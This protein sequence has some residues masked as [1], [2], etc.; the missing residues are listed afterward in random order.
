[1]TKK[2]PDEPSKW[3]KRLVYKVACPNCW[4]SFFPE[5]VLFIA[6]HPGLVG[7][8]VAGSNEYLRF[9]PE[10]FTVKGE[11][12]DPRGVP[13]ADL[14]CPRCHLR[15]PEIMLE[16]HPLFISLI[17]S[18]ASGKSY[19]LT[20]M[21]HSLRTILPRAGLQFTDADPHANEPILD[22][23]RTLFANPHTNRPT[24]IRKSQLDDTR[25]HRFIRSNEM[26]IRVPVPLQFRLWPQQNHPGFSDAYSIG[27][28]IVMYD[29]AGEDFRP[30]TEDPQ[31][32]AARHLAASR[33]L[34]VLLDLT[35]EPQFREKS[36]RND[37][38]LK[39]GL[40]PGSA[41]QNVVDSQQ[42]IL[43]EAAVRLRRYLGISEKDRVRTPL[44][45]IVPKFDIWEEL[46]GVS[47][48]EEPYETSDGNSLLAM[49]TDAVDEV[50]RQI[51]EV[52]WRFCPAFVSTA[53]GLSEVVRYVPVS[54]L[55]RSP[56]FIQQEGAGYYGICPRDISPKW[57]TVPLLYCL[58]KWA[59][60][61]IARRHKDHQH[62][63]QLS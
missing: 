34:F 14:A 6:K 54:S 25:L 19:F 33:I 20:A 39:H 37:P 10:R 18:P 59:P 36:T 1:M 56:E 42:T 8:P 55:G 40:R 50:S 31:A 57:V 58:C 2:R 38:Q 4:Q 47:I 3:G 23:E 28:V 29:N 24:E 49:N 32:A 45:V 43:N 62:G 53:E 5:E 15:I 35:Q 30:G 17:G 13:T 51:R 21:T 12:L 61:M 9:L 48:S 44:I 22:Y 7:D 11:A 60:G 41:K 26:D 63:R 52:L 16:V 27:R 46:V